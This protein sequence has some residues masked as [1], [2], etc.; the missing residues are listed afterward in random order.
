MQGK[1]L[2]FGELLLRMSPQDDWAA[3]GALPFY[4]G[5]AELN[6]ATALANWQLPVG[7]V[8][9]LPDNYL[10]DSLLQ[11]V[12]SKN[13][14]AAHI[15]KTNGRLGMYYL[16]EG[17]EIKSS[18]VVYDRENSAFA[19]LKPG[20]IDWDA[21]LKGCSWLHLSAITPALNATVAAVCVEAAKAAAARGIT[22]SIDLNYRQKL[23]Q[24]G[25]QPPVIMNDILPYCNVV[26]GNIWSANSLLDVPC[27][28]DGTEPP[29]ELL[30]LAKQ[31]MAGIMQQYLGVHT[32][33][34]TFRMQANY[35]AVALQGG[36][37][38]VSGVYD[39]VNATGRVGS[40]DC[41]MAGLVYGLYTQNDAQYAV[42][43]ATAAA[44]GKLYEQ[45]DATTQ[46]VDDVTKRM[47][48]G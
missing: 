44:T 42:S 31:S 12:S 35:W 10:S 17:H 25:V 46:T 28:A 11:Y 39:T 6:V 30:E 24:Y 14:D 13:I 45:G 27:A 1:I 29:S 7:Y 15:L 18:G 5:G 2:C 8:T 19:G 40:G 38:S 41:F 37:V 16:G 33:A 9:A 4:I 23:W 22:V 36:E 47:T 21:A 48:N 34:Y 32:C 43:F 20:D 26:M 3:Q